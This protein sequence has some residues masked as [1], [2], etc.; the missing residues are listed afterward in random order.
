MGIVFVFLHRICKSMNKFWIAVASAEHVR[1]GQSQG[2]MQVCHGKGAPLRRLQ[3]GDIVVYYSPA[4]VFGSKQAYQAFTA[5]GTVLARAPY[6]VS[7]FIDD[8][9]TFHPFRRDVD[10]FDS[11]PCS[12][13]PL[14]N[15]LEFSKGKTNWAYP[16]RFGLAE[17]CEADM[18][19][20]AQAMRVN[21]LKSKSC[22]IA[23]QSQSEFT[24]D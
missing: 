6:Q 11:H 24:F 19:L 3:K 20:I 13:R 7:M 21:D 2:F 17:I 4:E 15:Q 12:I 23:P 5:I 10:W 16:L 8:S 1:L 22:R 14:L 18:L 9:T